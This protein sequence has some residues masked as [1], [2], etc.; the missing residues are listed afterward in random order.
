MICLSFRHCRSL[1]RHTLK[2]R[3]PSYTAETVSYNA[4]N[5]EHITKTLE[6]ILDLRLGKT[7]NSTE[8]FIVA[9]NTKQTLTCLRDCF[10]LATLEARFIVSSASKNTCCQIA[11]IQFV[12]NVLR[13]RER[14]FCFIRN[15]E[16]V[17][18][19]SQIKMARG[20]LLYHCLRK[21]STRRLVHPYYNMSVSAAADTLSS[22]PDLLAWDRTTAN[23]HVAVYKPRAK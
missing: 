22:T 5:V 4:V 17:I 16:R 3:V 21:K 23:P 8:G 6:N 1:A 14:I 19:V 7:V 15:L 13:G 10:F 12:E 18:L 9:S 20:R 2:G 11:I